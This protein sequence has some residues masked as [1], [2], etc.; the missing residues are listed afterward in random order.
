MEHQYNMHG[1]R[2][3]DYGRCRKSTKLKELEP[4]VMV[5]GHHLSWLKSSGWNCDVC[6]TCGN[7]EIFAN[8]LEVRCH[9][10]ISNTE[11]PI[12]ET[13]PVTSVDTVCEWVGCKETNT[14]PIYRGNFCSTHLGPICKIRDRISPHDGSF[15]ELSARIEEFRVRRSDNIITYQSHL[16]RI[17]DLSTLHIP[18]EQLLLGLPSVFHPTLWDIY[19]INPYP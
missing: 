19:S 6:D 5:C 4:D 1:N 14:C 13:I 12:E 9:Y 11:S 3:C 10:K 15:D 8:G 7:I 18:F 17:Y 16:R 2:T